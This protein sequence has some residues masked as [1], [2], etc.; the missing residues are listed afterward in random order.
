M[1]DG[2]PIPWPEAAR[3]GAELLS[4][5]AAI[6]AAGVVHRDVKPGN[7]MLRE[8]GKSTA[9]VLLDMGL[10]KSLN[11][12]AGADGAS[13]GGD[14]TRHAMPIGTFFYMSPE[15][16]N[17]GADVTGSSDVY[18]LGVTLYEVL[19]GRPPFVGTML[20]LCRLHDKETPPPIRAARPDVPIAFDTLIRKMLEKVPAHRGS[21]AHLAG[22]LRKLAAATPAAQ[23]PPRPVPSRAP[24]TAVEWTPD[25]RP[26]ARP[27]RPDE[28]VV[29][30]T[31][32]D[33]PAPMGPVGVAATGWRLVRARLRLW[34]G[35]PSPQV[36]EAAHE[37]TTRREIRQ[38]SHRFR[39]GLRDRGKMLVYPHRS[40]LEGLLLLGTVALLLRAFRVW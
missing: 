24:A 19:A 39:S 29:A 9:A 10:G 31:P 25:S 28:A 20:Q 11:E 8:Q 35:P 18:S 2:T 37:R 36:S 3:W 38:L 12:V 32:A 1:R 33:R 4:A 23:P 22:E 13:V 15:Q 14:L 21:A 30:R 34:A 6:H 26:V 5:L 27:A 17:S 40:P 16:W 7:V